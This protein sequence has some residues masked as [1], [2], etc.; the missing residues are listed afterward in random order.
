MIS[1]VLM[2]TWE[3]WCYCVLVIFRSLS[4]AVEYEAEQG[5]SWMGRQCTLPMY[6]R[7]VAALW[8]CKAA[9]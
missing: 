8:I 5:R 9:Y 7:P 4:Y 6:T 2:E 1:I 3:L